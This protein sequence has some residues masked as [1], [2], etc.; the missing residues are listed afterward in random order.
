[1]DFTID[2][3][4]LQKSCTRTEGNSTQITRRRF[5]ND[6]T[7]YLKAKIKAQ[8]RQVNTFNLKVTDFHLKTEIIN[9]PWKNTVQPTFHYVR[10]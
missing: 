10:Y 2:D 4:K 3:S 6:T 7:L 5:T 8:Q 9:V 1:M